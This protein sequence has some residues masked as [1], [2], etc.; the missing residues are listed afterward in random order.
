MSKDQAERPTDRAS[1]LGQ[2]FEEVTGK[3]IV[4]SEHPVTGEVIK[5]ELPRPE[6][7]KLLKKME[8]EDTLD[9]QENIPKNIALMVALGS[10]IG[11][12]MWLTMVYY[13]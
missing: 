3:Q 13:S 10:V 8:D 4:Y 6:E 11:F 7:L 5:D 9:L 2:S 12:C 1:D